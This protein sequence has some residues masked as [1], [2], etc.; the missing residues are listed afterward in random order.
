MAGRLLPADSPT[1]KC[2]RPS[3]RGA[4]G[5]ALVLDGSAGQAASATKCGS[6]FWFPINGHLSGADGCPL[7]LRPFFFSGGL[8]G[9]DTPLSSGQ[10]G[11]AP[12]GGR[13]TDEKVAVRWTQ[14]GTALLTPPP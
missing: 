8:G 10:P 13:R 9:T 14:T 12:K 2:L 5:P 1:P 6:F 3:I 11:P 7:P 4:A